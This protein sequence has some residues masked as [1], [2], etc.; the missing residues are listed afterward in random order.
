MSIPDV[1]KMLAD[2]MPELH[3]AEVK[4]TEKDGKTYI[5]FVKKVGAKG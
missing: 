4:Q 3:N 1:Q 5:Q 2:F